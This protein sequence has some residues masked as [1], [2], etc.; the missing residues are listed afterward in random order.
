MNFE[1]YEL[2]IFKIQNEEFL[3]SRMLTNSIVYM[4][5]IKL[6]DLNSNLLNLCYSISVD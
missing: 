1:L 5:C 4:Y 6:S 2:G 3:L